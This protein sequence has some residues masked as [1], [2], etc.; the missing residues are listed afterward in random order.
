VLG[1]CGTGVGIS[2]LFTS[3][4]GWMFF[5]LVDHYITDYCIV[6]IALLECIAVGW[7]FEAHETASRSEAHERGMKVLGFL[8]WFPVIIISIYCHF[9]VD[10]DDQIWGVVAMAASS[11]MAALISFISA[12]ELGFGSWYHEIFACGTNKV[13]MGITSISYADS[14]IEDRSWWMLMFEGWFG[15]GVKFIN[16]ALLTYLLI[17]NLQADLFEPYA[18]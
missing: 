2:F 4:W 17:D 6:S 7:V 13:A 12:R 5:D 1:A 9:G 10:E 8:Y 18:D 14:D 11:L 16:P 15:V 3:S